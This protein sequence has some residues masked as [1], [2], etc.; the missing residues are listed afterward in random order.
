M[1]VNA[2]FL[3]VVL[4][5]APL[6]LPQLLAEVGDRAPAVEVAAASIDVRSA[7]VEVAGTWDDAELTVMAER[8][9]LPGGDSEEPVMITY[10]IGQPLNLFG[11]RQAARQVART[12]VD[13]E[14]AALRR[15]AWDARARAVELFYELWM[16]GE[17]RRIVESQLALLQRMRASALGRVRAGM[18]TGHHDVLRAESQIA[19]MEAER[20]SL[21]DER[22]AVVAMLNTLRGKPPDEPLGDPEL[23]VLAPLPELDTATAAARAAP[24]VEAATAMVAQAEAGEVVARKMYL[25]MVMVEAQYEQNVGMPDG[26]G[27]A[28]GLRVPLWWGRARNEV[29]MARAM[30]RAA[31]REQDAM[32]TMADAEARMAWSRTR[33]SERT[34]SALEQTA[35]PRMRETVASIEVAYVAGRGEFLSLLDAI[36]ELRELE[37][38]RVQAVAT[39]GVTRF[40]LDRIAGRAVAP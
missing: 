15:V 7:A 37:G 11:R 25:P 18:D 19:V 34:L 9:P 28:L 12:A 2:C 40:E 33:A 17:M 29:A 38:R 4:A 21:D 13:R 24:E 22:A 39:R 6:R 30:K 5:P 20:A 31:V 8:L 14:R 35:I 1:L 16:N 32:R 36:M 26:F 27:L 10:R 3:L 23:P